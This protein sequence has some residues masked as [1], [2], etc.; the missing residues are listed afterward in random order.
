MV[1]KRFFIKNIIALFLMMF[2]IGCTEKT[3]KIPSGIYTSTESGSGEKVEIKGNTIIFHIKINEVFWD[4]QFSGLSLMPDGSIAFVMAS[5]EFDFLYR[6]YNWT[7][8]GKVIWKE[9]VGTKKKISFI[10]KE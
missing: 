6:H 7:F 5:T 9:D 3:S 8:D 10:R 1:T 4:R 2:L